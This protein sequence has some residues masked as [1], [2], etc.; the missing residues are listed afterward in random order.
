MC[1]LRYEL[2]PVNAPFSWPKSWLSIGFSGMVLQLMATNGPLCCALRRWSACAT[3]SLPVPLS[4]RISTGALVGATLRMSSADLQAG[5]EQAA[6]CT[7]PQ[8]TKGPDR[9]SPFVVSA[10]KKK[11][12]RGTSDAEFQDQP[13]HRPAA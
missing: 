6:G 8:M 10:R 9:S 5:E 2:A 4:P 12:T 7:R 11:V 1:P 3:I 13:E